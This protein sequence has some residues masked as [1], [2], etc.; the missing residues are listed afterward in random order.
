MTHPGPQPSRPAATAARPKVA[1]VRTTP[2]TVLDDVGRAMRLADYQSALPAGVPVILK[3]N[4][5]WQHWYP[6]CS[7]TPWQLDGVIRALREDGYADLRPAQNGTVVVDSYEGEV[8]NKHKP[9]LDHHGLHSVH[10]D[11][12]GTDWVTYEPK[13]RHA[14]P[15]RYLPGGASPS[16]PASLATASSSSPPS[17]PTSSPP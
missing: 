2:A 16:P 5:S 4:I 9:V 7:T 11:V 3:P 12:P 10:L 8:R 14:C 17:R 13:G 15:P 6:A 1:V